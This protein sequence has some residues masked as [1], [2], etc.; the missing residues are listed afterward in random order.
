[1]SLIH[2]HGAVLQAWACLALVFIDCVTCELATVSQLHVTPYSSSH[3][4][5]S[6]LDCSPAISVFTLSQHV[7]YN[8]SLVTNNCLLLKEN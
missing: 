6:N 3:P 1:M 5:F 2:K 4:Q 7:M 8:Y